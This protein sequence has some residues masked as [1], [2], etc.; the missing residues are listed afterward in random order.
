MDGGECGRENRPAL[1]QECGDEAG[2]HVAAACRGQ[3]GVAGGVDVPV[4]VRGG[5]DAAAALEYNDGA[6]AA[7]EFASGSGPVGLYFA[8][9]TTEQ[10]SG[11][12]RVRGEDGRRGALGEQGGK[13][14]VCREQIE[15]VG[16]ECQ[17]QI[18]LQCP[19]K[20]IAGGV[21]AAQTWSGR[22]RGEVR[23]E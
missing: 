10:A 3:T 22:E 9:A 11:F 5:D 8:C 4:A 2:E 19:L 6:V 21:A 18:G 1:R 17:G 15:C 13:A 23:S 7:S 12:S 14:A 16:I 20:Q